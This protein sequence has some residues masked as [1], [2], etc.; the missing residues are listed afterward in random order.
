MIKL[1]TLIALLGLSQAVTFMPSTTPRTWDMETRGP[2]ATNNGLF[3]YPDEGLAT[4]YDDNGY[5]LKHFAKVDAGF[6]TLYAGNAAGTK[7]GDM[8]SESYGLQIWSYAKHQAILNVDNYYTAT[9]ET[10]LEPLYAAPYIQ[11][12]QWNRFEDADGF[13]MTVA[14]S[15]EIQMLDWAVTTAELASTFQ[16]SFFEDDAFDFSTVDTD[17]A[18]DET[19][20]NSFMDGRYSG[21]LLET[22]DLTDKVA[23][24]VGVHNYY[25][26]DLVK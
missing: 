19:F 22:F 26:V 8:R 14:G 13:K 7:T 23:D 18:Q 20:E 2:A 25:S 11:H 15:R 1:A 24:I 17:L 3:T 6:G 9:I 5:M 12:V 16:R 21:N 10:H 4:I